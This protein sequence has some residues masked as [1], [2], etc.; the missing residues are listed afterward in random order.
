MRVL[1]EDDRVML[2]R[3]C[4]PKEYILTL[5]PDLKNFVFDGIMDVNVVVSEATTTVVLHSRDLFI[6]SVSYK[7]DS[8]ASSI[9]AVEI[10]HNLRLHTLTL[11]FENVLPVGEGILM[12]KFQGE[13]NDQMAGFYR[14]SYKNIDGKS[15]IMASTQFEALDARRCFPCWDEPALKA[16]FDVTLIISSKLCAYSNM[17]EVESIELAGGLRR[18]HF[19]KTPKMST[20][21]L[22]FI[23]GEFDFVQT[24]TR[25]GVSVRVFTPPGKS[26]QGRF[27]LEVAAKSLDF[28]DDFFGEKYPLPKM[29][30]VAIPE[31]AMGA[32]E[33]WG[34]VTYREIDLLIDEKKA[35]SQQKQRVCTV[36]AHE[37]AHQ[38]FGNLVTMEW[39]DNL[40]L[41]EGFATWMQNFA[42][43]FLYPSWQMWDQF[44]LGAQA[45]A[46]SLDSLKTSHPVQVPIKHAEEVEEVFDAISYYKGACVVR[47]L[48]TTLGEENFRKGLQLYM[49]RHA[50]ANTKTTDLWGAWAEVSGLPI[51]EMMDC[52]TGQMGYPLVTVTSEE[53][54]KD[55]CILKVKQS[56]FLSDGSQLTKE[57]MKGRKPWRIPL[58]VQAQGGEPVL[59]FID[60]EEQTIS[61][62]L[63]KGENS[64]IKLN[65]GQSSMVHILYTKQ[66]SHQLCK[67][68]E[69]QELPDTDRAALLS[70]SCM[71]SSLLFFT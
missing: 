37:L 69:L 24:V 13:L 29:D 58:M 66:M 27:S 60:K 64:W 5:T 35:S 45:R 33:N 70:D 19:A 55:T 12:F 56:M 44:A 68:I 61:L 52:W 1:K 25:N 34:L 41:N 23:V 46:M 40:W 38:W 26:E 63:T 54:T 14:S 32:M 9:K 22:A 71:F 8:L 39:W 7:S 42:A 18:I 51:M 49:K 67:A 62:N 53:R 28:Y 59:Q 20:Y 21:L 10:N 43:D 11:V 47:M 57:E 31:F 16:T 65:A 6:K 36:V 17:P 4:L 3:K 48:Y 15:C 30:M 2:P 50:Y